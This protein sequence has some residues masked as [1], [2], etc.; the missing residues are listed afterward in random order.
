[1]TGQGQHDDDEEQIKAPNCPV[2]DPT[3]HVPVVAAAAPKNTAPR[4]ARKERAKR[5]RELPRNHVD[6]AGSQPSSAARFAAPETLVESKTRGA[7]D[8]CRHEM[9]IEGVGSPI[10]SF[11]G[12]NCGMAWCPFLALTERSGGVC[13]KERDTAAH[14]GPVASAA[15]AVPLW[16]NSGAAVS[17]G[18]KKGATALPEQR[19]A[20]A[21][22]R[23]IR[24][25]IGAMWKLAPTVLQPP[26]H[27]VTA[28]GA[29]P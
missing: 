3:P 18:T 20:S 28:A 8:S 10:S 13:A 21:F 6:S 26:V 16:G 9:K 29:Q 23:N 14:G 4:N 11:P 17:G 24:R 2:K 7:K 5:E 15:T 27:N 22:A 1:M 12:T 19:A 25:V